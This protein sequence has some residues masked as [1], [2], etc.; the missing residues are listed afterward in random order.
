VRAFAELVYQLRAEGP[1]P[2]GDRSRPLGTA[3][4]PEAKHGVDLVAHGYIEQEY[5]L[6]GHAGVWSWDKRLRPC[7]TEERPFTTRVLVRRP[8]DPTRFSGAVQLEPHHPDDDRA[9]TWAMIAP[10]IVRSRHAHVGVT[11]DQATADDLIGFDPER[12]GSLHISHPN[13]RWEIVALVAAA[14]VEGVIPDFVEFAVQRTVMSGW[15]MT[16]TFCRT[17]LGE[18]F[19]DRCRIDDR[20]AVS[21][22][23]ICISSGG[24]GR[25]GYPSLREGTALALEDSR[26]RIGAHG[27]PVVELLSEGEAETHRAVLRADA[28][29]PEDLYR[30]YEVAGTGHI[31]TGVPSVGT[32]RLQ[33]EQR[34][35]PA[36]AREINER[37]SDARMDLVARAVFEAIDHW[38][39]DRSP[40]PRA[41]RFDYADPASGA[42]RGLFPEALPLVRN[43]DGNVL[44]GVRTPWV[45]VPTAAYLPHST[46][47]PG[48]C[49][50]AAHAPYSDPAMLADLIA[51]M[52]PFSTAEL[53]RRYGTCEH[54]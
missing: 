2:V 34:G 7:C 5:L 25:A 23:V 46:A 19:H 32:N 48:R 37:P 52:K 1:L 6:H 26:R 45:E 10:W 42:P 13:Q 8:V 51:H 29:G 54:Y 30:L 22:Y 9:L 12:Y 53:R 16:G 38:I 17:F 40:P 21:G 35:W 15:S 18:R 43:A 36:P 4:L 28:D 33:L 3:W 49:Q 41:L 20:P 50:P 44:G 24:A 11:Q 39:A 47:R 27:V 31:T 14:I